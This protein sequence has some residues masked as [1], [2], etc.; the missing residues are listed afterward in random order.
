MDAPFGG[1]EGVILQ[2]GLNDELVD[3][4][5]GGD[6]VPK[7]AVA[8]LQTQVA[9]VHAV[10]GDGD[11]RL[12]AE[13][14]VG[15]VG[16]HRSLLAG[17]VAVEGV[18]QFAAEEVVVQH[19]AADQAH[20]LGAERGTAGGH[21]GGHAGGMH[22]HHVG[23]ALHH[24]RLVLGGNVA[25]RLIDAEEHLRLVIQ[26]RV[27]GVHVLAHG[28]VVE[29]FARAETD[30]VRRGILNRPNQATAKLINRPAFALRGNTGVDEFLDLK[31]LAQQVLRQRVPTL[32]G[33]TAL[34]I[35]DQLARKP[36]VEQEIAC[37]LRLRRFQLLAVKLVR[38]LIRRQQPLARSRL[39][40]TR[41]R[42]PAL[43]INAVPNLVRNRLH[44]LREGQLLHLHQEREHIPALA[45]GEAVVITV[46]RAN[47]ETRRLLVLERA[48]ALQRVVSGRLQLHIL[49]HDLVE[50]CALT[51]SLN[52]TIR[53]SAPC[54]GAHRSVC[55]D[56]GL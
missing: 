44:R 35:H 23:V 7:S 14:R 30:R 6:E 15:V 53:N 19:Q 54:H 24:H 22:R 43:V 18:D 8:L 32:G 1:V 29:K 41:T 51:D 28:V 17:L 45:R 37:D 26:H 49:A 36:T 2:E 46:S 39:H 55:N 21:G 10:R 52:V 56:M 50:R 12:A 11:K 4:D 13:L 9:R 33:V 42:R 16:A 25:L 20:V 38:R 34:E 31:P 3:G 27:G 47:V 5:A 48:Q 40:I